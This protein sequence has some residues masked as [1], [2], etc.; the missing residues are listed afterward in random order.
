MKGLWF[1]LLMTGLAYGETQVYQSEATKDG[2][3][4]YR[5]KHIVEFEGG[6]VKSSVTEYTAPEGKLLA[7]LTN[8]YQKSLNSPENTMDDLRGKN[9]HGVRYAGDQLLMF[10]QDEGAREEIKKLDPEDSKGKLVVGG[11][12]LHYYLVKNLEEVIKRGKLD[13]KFLIPGR[14]D[15]YDFYLKVAGKEEETVTFEIEIDNWFLRLFAPKL[16]LVYQRKTP[17]LLRYSG[18]SNIRDEKKEMM[19]VDIRYKYAD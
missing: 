14:L 8:S 15:A 4:V 6:E 9:K 7:R 2:K 13:L 12:G 1:F 5:E 17:R 3:L 18:L 10:N 16:K 19:N 11:Q